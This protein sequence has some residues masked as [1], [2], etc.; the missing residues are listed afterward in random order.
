[1]LLSIEQGLSAESDSPGLDWP[2]GGDP[3]PFDLSPP[4][5]GFYRVVRNG[6]WF[7]GLTNGTLLTG[8][9]KL[10]IEVGSLEGTLDSV[11]INA[12]GAPIEGT[13]MLSE[14]FFGQLGFVVDTRR[15]VNGDYYL[16]GVGTWWLSSTNEFD[17]TEYQLYSPSVMVTISNRISY[18][19]W[20][21]DYR[22]G[23]MYI[24]ATSAATNINWRVDIYGQSGGYVGTFTNHSDDGL[25]DTSW[26]LR[27]SGGT[28]HTND[29]F[30]T[31]VTTITPP[32]SPSFTDT[33]PPLIKVV[34]NFPDHGKWMVARAS[35]IPTTVQNYDLYTNSVNGF[36]QMGEN[37]GGVLP[38]QPY[39]NN[40]QAMVLSRATGMTNW[41]QMYDV[42]LNHH[43]VRNFYFDG[44]GSPHTL[45][46]G[47]D[48]NGQPTRTITDS[49]ISHALGNDT[50]GTNSTRFRWVWLD[51]CST[52]LGGWPEAFGMGNRT[53]VALTNYVSR[54]GAFCGWDRDT[55]AW[56]PG[57]NTINTTSID[58]RTF[59]VYYWRINGNDLIGAF[60][61]AAFWSQ[62]DDS[63][64]QVYGYWELLWDEYD[65]KAEWPP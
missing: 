3:G 30:F 62:F 45:G 56:T 42:F 15:L 25:I 40:G 60:D 5:T 19:G 28:A 65:T 49:L 34:D 39:R 50:P 33:A 53:N 63:H 64:L 27:D 52:A 9:A 29:T 24:K 1:M 59:F 23:L 43:E 10:P 38:G 54:P 11:T 61:E 55:Y 22:D 18:P 6:V 51:S 7:F 37:A 44:H 16:Q 57:N 31:A 41:A 8:S 47:Y 12:S 14:P 46:P 58:F 4:K 36:A 35:Y 21:Q 2:P 20:V 17:T 13:P 48:T 26:D 32:G